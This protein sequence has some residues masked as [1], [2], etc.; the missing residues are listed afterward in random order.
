MVPPGAD[1]A[2]ANAAVAMLDSI[3]GDPTRRAAAVAS[4]PR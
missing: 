3:E 4:I 2:D 1:L